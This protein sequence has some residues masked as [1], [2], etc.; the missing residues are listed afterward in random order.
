MIKKTLLLSAILTCC[1]SAAFSQLSFD[2]ELFSSTPIHKPYLA[3]PTKPGMSIEALLLTGDGPSTVMYQNGNDIH[4]MEFKSEPSRSFLRIKYG[5]ALG[6]ARCTVSFEHWLS[7]IKIDFSMQ[8]YLNLIFDDSLND[9][10]GLDGIYFIGGTLSI[11]DKVTMRA[12][13]H[14]YCSH[15]GDLILNS[16]A[17]SPE[18]TKYL[19]MNPAVAGI[20]V[21]PFDWLK[22]YGEMKW[23][24]KGMYR[25]RPDIYSP[26]FLNGMNPS[27]P[28]SYKAM[29]I[30]AGL[31]LEYKLFPRL[32]KTA[33]GY[34][35]HLYQ[36]GKIILTD[37]DSDGVYQYHYDEA[38]PWEMEHTV[39]V[40]QD[41]AEWFT[42]EAAYHIGRFPLNG[43]IHCRTPYFSI[44]FR[45][46]SQHA[47]GWSFLD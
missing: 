20:A 25:I 26:S 31:E 19:R 37:N 4:F 27:Y 43:L 10:Y 2:F 1:M 9:M 45:F 11:A 34:D 42:V 13:I 36:E 47:L 29:I 16:L 21:K 30:N 17:P 38:A 40:A 22:V 5:A 3:D 15:Y 7:P 8:G 41:L 39:M 24:H 46:N 32:G 44:N 35:I 12:G 28:D 14:H 23:A 18:R 6:L 33:V